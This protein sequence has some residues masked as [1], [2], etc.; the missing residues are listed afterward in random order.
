MEDLAD[1]SV[2]TAHYFLN[3]KS[4]GSL[5]VIGPRRMPYGRIVS[6]VNFMASQFGQTLT[7]WT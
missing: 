4:V 3:E 7:N 5:G 2:V 6:L 1:C